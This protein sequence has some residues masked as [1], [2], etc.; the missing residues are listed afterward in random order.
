MIVSEN[1]FGLFNVQGQ[2]KYVL[3]DS[4]DKGVFKGLS[5]DGVALIKTFN[6]NKDSLWK[7]VQLPP[8]KE[9]LIPEYQA[10]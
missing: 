7:D 3:W 8:V 6:G 4:F 2:V 10:L 9:I 5:R 1:H